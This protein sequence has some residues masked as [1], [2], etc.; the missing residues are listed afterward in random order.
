[1]ITLS[2]LNTLAYADYRCALK[3]AEASVQARLG[4]PVETAMSANHGCPATLPYKSFQHAATA[5][6]ADMG[7]DKVAS[8]DLIVPKDENDRQEAAADN[9][10]ELQLHESKGN[11]SQQQGTAEDAT[12]ASD[13]VQP[14][15]IVQ[16]SEDGVAPL[17]KVSLSIKFCSGSLALCVD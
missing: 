8:Q 3:N 2:T 4:P 15:P 13:L 12:A 1:M 7:V 17:S 6:T 11:N 10:V 16:E 9:Q 14:L 5:P